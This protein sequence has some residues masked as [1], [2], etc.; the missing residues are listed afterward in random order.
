[1]TDIEIERLI[2]SDRHGV[3]RKPSGELVW[4]PVR[5]HYDWLRKGMVFVCEAERVD[6]E[7]VKRLSAETEALRRK[8]AS[9][10]IEKYG[11][12]IADE[13][14]EQFKGLN[15]TKGKKIPKHE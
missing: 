11:D 4:L 7:K 1:M 5:R 13:F 12:G 14:P 6:E 8:K 9:E 10:L 3:Y 15:L 2:S